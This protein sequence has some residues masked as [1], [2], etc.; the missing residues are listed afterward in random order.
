VPNLC[1]LHPRP[2]VT[3]LPSE[4][5]AQPRRTFNRATGQV[6]LTVGVRARSDCHHEQDESVSLHELL[7]HTAVQ[8]VRAGNDSHNEHK[9]LPQM[10]THR[11][12]RTIPEISFSARFSEEIP[13]PLSRSWDARMA[14]DVCSSALG[15]LHAS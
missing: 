12:S 3:G 15:A 2:T 6:R 8:L 10:A 7:A 14:S 4:R 5:N 9:F 11:C 1:Q 13:M